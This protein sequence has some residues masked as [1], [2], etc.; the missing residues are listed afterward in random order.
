MADDMF[1][2]DDEIGT[3]EPASGGKRVGFLSGVLIQVLKWVG[4]IL[5][6]IIF[7]VTVVVVTVNFLNRGSVTQTRVPGSADYFVAEP[8]LQWFGDLGERRGSTADEVRTTF[9]VTPHL[10]YDQGDD[11]LQTELIQRRIQ[12]I[13]IV[14]DYFSRRTTAELQGPENSLRV[15]QELLM[16]INRIL[17]SGQIRDIVFES[18]QFLPF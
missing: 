9:I 1:D 8:I 10:G 2:A 18:Y 17:R 14:N 16:Q 5:G 7:I 13:G 12:L 15:K 6:A 3:D 4:I 11:R